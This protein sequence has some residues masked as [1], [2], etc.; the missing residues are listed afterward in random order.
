ML[1]G[2]TFITFTIV[3]FLP[4]NPLAT[5][6]GKIP[7]SPECGQALQTSEYHLKDPVYIQYFYYLNGLAHLQSDILSLQESQ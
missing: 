1:L 6:L 7:P 2:A 5:F 4:V 3:D